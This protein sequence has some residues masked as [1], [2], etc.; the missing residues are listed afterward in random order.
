MSIYKMIIHHPIIHLSL[1]IIIHHQNLHRP[2]HLQQ[3]CRRRGAVFSH[4]TWYV[5][6][7]KTLRLYRYRNDYVVNIC[8]MGSHAE[9]CRTPDIY[10]AHCLQHLTS[11]KGEDLNVI[12]SWKEEKECKKCFNWRLTVSFDVLVWLLALPC[13]IHKCKS[14]AV[15]CICA[16]VEKDI[17][18][19]CQ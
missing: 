3:S 1:C 14:K 7:I 12:L 5:N 6:W 15:L 16:S 8:K 2:H 18:L 4:I 17:H 10:V 19:L 9:H 13:I 11:K